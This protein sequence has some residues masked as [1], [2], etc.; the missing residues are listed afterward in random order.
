MSKQDTEVIGGVVCAVKALTVI[1][2]ECLCGEGDHHPLC[3]VVRQT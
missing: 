1:H 3:R 2:H